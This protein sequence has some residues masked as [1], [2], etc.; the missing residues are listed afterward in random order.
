MLLD[1]GLDSLGFL[2][3]RGVLFGLAHQHAYLLA[4]AVAVRAQLVR[5]CNRRAAFGIQRDDL[6]HQG[7]L[8]ILEL[9]LD[10]FLDDLGILPD[11]T[12]I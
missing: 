1:L 5:L 11:K 6:V 8:G 12:D 3:L 2:Q 7:Q 10:I 4:Q 9:L